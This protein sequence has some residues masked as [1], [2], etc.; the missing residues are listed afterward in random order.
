MALVDAID[1]EAGTR[2]LGD[3]LA[4][5]EDPREALALGVRL[6]RQLNQRCGDIIAALLSAATVEPAA[7]SAMAEGKRRHREGSA[8]LGRKLGALGALRDDSPPSRAAALI[9]VLTWHP[10]YAQLTQEH[11]WSFDDC[12][13]WITTTLERALLR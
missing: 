9:A 7:A 8:R 11:G 4:A 3:Q 12:E 6:T 5:S 1:E 2:A 10:A 13:Q